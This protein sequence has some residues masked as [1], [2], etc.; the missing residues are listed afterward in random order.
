MYRLLKIPFLFFILLLTSPCLFALPDDEQKVMHI[1]SDS[2][3]FNYKT[4]TNT[5]EGH[6]KMD[7]GTTHLTADRVITTKNHTTRKI[8]V[9]IAYGLTQ[10]AEY[11]TLPK[12]GDPVLHAKAKIIK[13]YPAQSI[14]FLQDDVVVTQG[15][16]SFQG[17]VIVYNIKDQIVTAPPSKT[18][19]STII[20]DPGQLKS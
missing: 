17:P 6:V 13:F 1:C 11:T 7:Q 12:P 3:T 9:A 19:R 18:G 4:G 20:I 8:E 15:K 5:Y 14:V 2:S 16:N 10:W